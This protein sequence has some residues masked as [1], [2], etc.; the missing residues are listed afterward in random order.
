[1]TTKQ[2]LKTRRN[3]AG[4]TRGQLAEASGISQYKIDR[5]E[6]GVDVGEDVR[7]AYDA[8][9]AKLLKAKPAT[10]AKKTTPKPRARTRKTAQTAETAA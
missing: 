8:G 10:A 4:I 5:I 2:D 6:R 7:K 3:Q 1:M 9:L